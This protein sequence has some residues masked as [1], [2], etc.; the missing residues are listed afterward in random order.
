VQIAREADSG[1]VALKKRS[2]VGARRAAAIGDLP[3]GRIHDEGGVAH[4]FE[5][6]LTECN[7]SMADSTTLRDCTPRRSLSSVTARSLAQPDDTVSAGAIAARVTKAVVWCP[8]YPWQRLLA[9]ARP[10]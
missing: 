8:T 5:A 10:P 3:R 7:I 2:D 4:Q 1:S 6:R 9:G